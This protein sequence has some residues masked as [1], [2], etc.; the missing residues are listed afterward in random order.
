MFSDRSPEDI[1]R[2]LSLYFEKPIQLGAVMQGCNHGN[3]QPL[4]IFFHREECTE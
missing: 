4:W 1:Q 2:F 3:G